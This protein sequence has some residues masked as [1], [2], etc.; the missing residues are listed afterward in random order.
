[1]RDLFAIGKNREYLHELKDNRNHAVPFIGAGFS[2]GFCPTWAEF[3]DKYFENMKARDELLPEEVEEFEQLRKTDRSDRLE[4]MA[5]FLVE[6]SGRVGFEEEMKRQMGVI[7]PIER[8]KKFHLLQRTFPFL[9]ITTNYDSLI[10]TTVP[11]GVYVHVARGNQPE[12]LKRLFDHRWEL[13]CL[14]KIHGGIDDM[15]S[16][17]L[18]SKQ[19]QELYGHEKRYDINTPLPTFLKRVF[20]NAPVLFMGC[21]LDRD[22]TAMILEDL[23]DKPRHYCL[24]KRPEQDEERIPLQRRLKNLGICPIWLEDYS[25]V[26]EILVWLAGDGGGEGVPL[27]HWGLFVGREKELD[28]IGK[29]LGSVELQTITGRLYNIDGAGGVGKTALALEAAQRYK[30]KFSDGVLP[31]FRVD[32]HT[33]VSFAMA[34]AG[35][36]G[37]KIQE[38]ESNEK[39]LQDVT[40]LLQNRHCLL[41]LD[42]AE[43]WEDLRYM[44]PER[45]RASILVTTRNRDFHRKIRNHYPQLK[46]E[47]IPLERFTEKEALALFQ[48][49]LAEEFQEEEKEIYLEIAASL[50]Y[51]PIA[52]RQAV[53]LMVYTPHYRATELRDKLKGESKLDLLRQG[54]AEAESDSRV[55]ETVFDL[56][57]PVLT[58]ELKKV[59]TLL[60]VCA[61][62]PVPIDFLERLTERISALNSKEKKK[63]VTNNGVQGTKSLTRS[64]EGDVC[65]TPGESLE[66]LYTYSWCE[67]REREGE[68]F[69]ELHQLVR[70][71]LREPENPYYLPYRDA[72]V[73]QV[74]ELFMDQD[75]HF[76]IKDRYYFQLEEAFEVMKKEKDQRLKEDWLY[77]LYDFCVYRGYGHFYLH[78]TQAVEEL[79]PDDKW[80]LRGAYGHRALILMSFGKFTEAMTCHKKQEAITEELDDRKGLAACYGNQALILA[81]W[82]KL[83]EAMALHKKEE[84]IC[85]ELGDRAGLSTCY[86]NQALILKAWGKLEESMALH[87]KEEVISKEI[88]NRAQLALSFCGQALI[89]ADW[90]KLEEAMDLHKKEEAIGEELGDRAGLAACYGN[91]A[92][93]HYSKGN[94]EEAMALQKKQEA[95]CEELGDRA[96]LAACWWN[97]GL[98]YEKQGNPH[99]QAQLW[100]KSIDTNKSMG[101]PTADKEKYLKE[102]LDKIN[103]TDKGK[104]NEAE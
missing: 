47:E 56:S 100:Q 17:V 37:A 23:T 91:Q 76:S 82:G 10:E 55:I 59:L 19:Y 95:I 62:G 69:Y 87:K 43:N 92:N 3:L 25:Q 46:S 94:L 40:R 29:N 11:H 86:G 101:I 68:R 18:G 60:A 73:N 28:F 63:P 78:L 71:L 34:L 77:D 99:T 89:L 53:S 7:V 1:M 65:S 84:A 27:P 45:S 38:P 80:C 102:L 26:E 4:A 12:E 30:D 75:V 85:E 31:L 9:K 104:G 74:H 14:L 36:L 57:A 79:F 39:A 5:D 81:D 64:R 61:A 20:T 83:E 2:Y 35:Y 98:I 33:P 21:S 67:R 24:V 70:E 41:I 72:F 51:L 66:R 90:G 96:G 93:I 50:G 22:R 16:I 58:D 15:N 103:S 42:N 32:E 6:K 44:V 97:Q 8:A 13:N 48:R 54:C 49:M 88:G 52:L